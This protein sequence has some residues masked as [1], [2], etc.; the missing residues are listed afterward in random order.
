M[1][2]SAL[3]ASVICLAS[4]TDLRSGAW[5]VAL[6]AGDSGR[7]KASRIVL[8]AK[9][10]KDHKCTLCQVCIKNPDGPDKG[11]IS[12]FANWWSRSGCKAKL[13]FAKSEGAAKGFKISGNCQCERKPCSCEGTPCSPPA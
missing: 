2:I 11:K 10:D 3:V 12:C 4:A 5:A 8:M 6:A 9:D 13:A 1:S 7:E